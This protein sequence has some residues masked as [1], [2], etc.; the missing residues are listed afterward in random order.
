MCDWKHLRKLSLSWAIPY[1]W[2]WG[3]EPGEP[4]PG[5]D[6]PLIDDVRPP[7]LAP[8]EEIEDPDADVP[9]PAPPPHVDLAEVFARGPPEGPALALADIPYAFAEDYAAEIAEKLRYELGP[10]LEAHAEDRLFLLHEWEARNC[11]RVAHMMRRLAE[12]CPTLEEVEWVPTG[13]WVPPQCVRWA[14]KIHRERKG[15]KVLRVSGNLTYGQGVPY[16]PQ[17]VGQELQQM[18]AFHAW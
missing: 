5:S 4:N 10:T 2:L 13:A 9:A 8:D 12:C 1:I 14:W 16:L 17:L 18:R 7:V 3:P 11:P 15:G 6:L